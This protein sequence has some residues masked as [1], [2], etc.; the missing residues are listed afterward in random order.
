MIQKGKCL[1]CWNEIY[2][3]D[4]HFQCHHC[5]YAE[6]WSEEATYQLDKENKNDR[7]LPQ[8]PLQNRGMEKGKRGKAIIEKNEKNRAG[9]D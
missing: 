3:K 2:V 1:N 6:N 9:K 4:C 8:M 7:I 5:G